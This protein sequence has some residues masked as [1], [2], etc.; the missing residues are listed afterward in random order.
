MNS[1]AR[2][3]AVAIGGIATLVAVMALAAGT[4]AATIKH[5]GKVAG[6][7]EAKVTL[8]VKK[9]RGKLVRV[10]GVKIKQ[11]LLNCTGEDVRRNLKF[12][13]AKITGRNLKRK[14]AFDIRKREGYDNYS[15]S[16]TVK[17]KGRRVSGTFKF[18]GRVRG[19]RGRTE[20]CAASGS[21]KA[22]K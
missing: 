10:A 1:D 17:K 14:G 18:M 13:A 12:G 4:N 3:G 2:R 6:D 9:K 11:L 20:R 15:I 5:S 8:K 19:D 21:F 16:G 7:A 22:A